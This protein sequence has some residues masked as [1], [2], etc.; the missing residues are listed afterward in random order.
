MKS[1]TATGPKLNHAQKVEVVTRLAGFEPPSAIA[2]SFKEDLGIDITA[3]AIA[4]YDP[5]RYSSSPRRKRWSDLFWTTRAEIIAGKA[6]VGVAYGTVRLR[7]LDQMTRAQMEKLNTAEARALMKQAVDEMTRMAGQGDDGNDDNKQ[8]EAELFAEIEARA[9]KLGYA[10]VP[11]G[12]QA[13]SDE[14]GAGEEPGP[15][16]QPLSG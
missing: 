8:S 3:Q 6:D 11:F 7:W 14:G 4:F 12:D 9:A 13:A 1:A 15:A 5:T 16:D 2:K 10:I